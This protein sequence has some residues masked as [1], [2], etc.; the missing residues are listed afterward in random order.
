MEPILSSMNPK[1]E[2]VELGPVHR[3]KKEISMEVAHG[4]QKQFIHVYTYI[5]THVCIYNIK[6]YYLNPKPLNPISYIFGFAVVC[7][8]VS[9]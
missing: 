8:E 5:Y 7:I 6:F 3:P 2:A 9:T 4:L 1:L